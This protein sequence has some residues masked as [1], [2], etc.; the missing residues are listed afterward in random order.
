MKKISLFL[1]L[2]TLGIAFAAPLSSVYTPLEFG[3]CKAVSRFQDEAGGAVDLC[4]GV[5]GYT[6]QLEEGDLRQNVQVISPKGKKY[7]LD[8]WILISGSFSS[9]GPRAEWRMAGKVPKALIVRFNASENPEDSNKITSYLA[10]AKISSSGACLVAR[11]RPSANMNLEARRVS[12]RA[13][14]MSC[15]K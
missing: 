15:L 4:P 12:D 7:S 1:L 2:A 5:A 14:G 3:K 6:L 8:L 11:I 13:A 9:T 10:V